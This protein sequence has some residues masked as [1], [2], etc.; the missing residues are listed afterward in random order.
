MT[1]WDSARR[2]EFENRRILL[3]TGGRG[4]AVL[5]RG[6]GTPLLFLTA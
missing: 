5:R 6:I 4:R 1:G 3:V 2:R